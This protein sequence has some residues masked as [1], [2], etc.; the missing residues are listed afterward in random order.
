MRV[1]DFVLVRFFQGPPEKAGSW[2][3]LRSMYEQIWLPSH[4]TP[5]TVRGIRQDHG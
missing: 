4:R 1:V 3:D 5:A 2:E